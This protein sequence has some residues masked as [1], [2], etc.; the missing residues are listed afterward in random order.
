MYTLSDDED[1]VPP[2]QI[3]EFLE[4][5]LSPP[6]GA[7]ICQPAESWAREHMQLELACEK[8]GAACAYDVKKT[9]TSIVTK[10]NKLESQAAEKRKPNAPTK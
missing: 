6:R 3:R 5:Q 10:V 9:I 7:A 2:E 1:S 4:P 8:L